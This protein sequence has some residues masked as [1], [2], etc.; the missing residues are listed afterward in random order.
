MTRTRGSALPLSAQMAPPLPST[1]DL[2]SFVG[3]PRLAPGGDSPASFQAS[4]ASVI[5]YV[6]TAMMGGGSSAGGYDSLPSSGMGSAMTAPEHRHVFTSGGGAGSP[7][8]HPELARFNKVGRLRQAPPQGGGPAHPALHLSLTVVFL[9]PPNGTPSP[10]LQRLDLMPSSALQCPSDPFRNRTR[11]SRSSAQGST[12][13]HKKSRF[14]TESG[15]SQAAPAAPPPPH[16]TLGPP[17]TVA[18][19]ESPVTAAAAVTG[20]ARSYRPIEGWLQPPPPPAAPPFTCS[21][22]LVRKRAPPALPTL[23]VGMG[24]TAVK[25]PLVQ[26]FGLFRR[27]HRVSATGGWQ[28]QQQ[29]KAWG[30]L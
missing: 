19:E 3:G 26:F 17:A 10:P 15:R 2:Q 13:G 24:L 21:L 5:P 6:M 25:P 14:S 18:E 27:K 8:W 12:A 7:A 1:G 16:L 23:S 9:A 20:R 28:Q 29:Q 30:A 11:T 4:N 22:R